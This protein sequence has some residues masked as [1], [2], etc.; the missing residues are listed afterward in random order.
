VPT[1]DLRVAEVVEQAIHVGVGSELIHRTRIQ[2]SLKY[3]Q[4]RRRVRHASSLVLG[5]MHDPPHPKLELIMPGR[6]T[7]RS[8]ERMRGNR[9]A[10]VIR[11]R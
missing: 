3:E 7:D 4:D 11:R 5:H 6:S 8:W 2:L 10:L 9:R 1:G